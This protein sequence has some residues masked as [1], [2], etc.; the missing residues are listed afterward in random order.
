MISNND[1]IIVQSKVDLASRKLWLLVV[2]PPVI[3]REK[4]SKFQFEPLRR[5]L[6]GWKVWVDLGWHFSRNEKQ[7]ALMDIESVRDV[8]SGGATLELDSFN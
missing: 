6:N 1:F 4:I 3:T 5:A 2:C 7:I 8:R